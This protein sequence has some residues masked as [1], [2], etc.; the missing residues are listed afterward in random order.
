MNVK[1]KEKT[2]DVIG[3][4]RSKLFMAFTF[5]IGLESSIKIEIDHMLNS[6]SENKK[7]VYS[8][9]ICFYHEFY[10]FCSQLLADYSVKA[11]FPYPKDFSLQ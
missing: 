10:Y 6:L 3:K 8:I 4:K 5:V 7:A 9:K 11:V 2:Q 1:G